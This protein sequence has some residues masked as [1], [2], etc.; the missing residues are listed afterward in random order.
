MENLLVSVNVVLPLFLMMALGYVLKALHFYDD[1]LL[2]KMNNLVFKV[3]LPILLF[4]DLYATDLEQ[5]FNPRLILYAALS[6]LAAF[7]L[8]VAF[9][10]IAE[11]NN[12]IR[13]ALIQGIF[14][15]NFI[16]FGV[17]IARSIY[18]ETAAA[19]AAILIA[20]IIPM[21]NIL[22]VT[23]MEIFRGG[24]VKISSILKGIATNPLI[25]GCVIGFLFLFFKISLPT[26]IADTLSSLA[27]VATPLALMILG[28]SIKFSKTK[29]Y[30]RQIIYGL[31]GKLIVVPAIFLLIAVM[32]GFRQQEW[33]VLVALYCSPVAVSS[34]VMAQQMD[35][36]GDLAG[37]FVVLGAALSVV[38]VF[39]WVFL[40]KSL[41][42]L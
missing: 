18:G 15:S 9:A 33:A 8:S 3:F 20:V 16:I 21:F 39:L 5:V 35:S 6:V 1:T 4:T 32:L 10:C 19:S 34:F 12:R 26:V 13:S 36:D 11:K 42:F 29:G 24:S 7:F 41:G 23:E 22:T 40:L 37:Q 25:I 30:F 31:A 28:G 2:S 27:S 14:R 38:T 17:P